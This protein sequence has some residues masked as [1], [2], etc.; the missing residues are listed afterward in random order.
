M[1][2]TTAFVPTA[3]V[4]RRTGVSRTNLNSQI[5]RG[6][7]L[8]PVKIG[9]RNIA[10]PEHELEALLRFMISNPSQDELKAFV[11]RIHQDRMKSEV[12]A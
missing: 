7:F 3:E 12:L 2:N 6:L 11:T 8:E 1:Q 4:L 9:V 5:K 10:W